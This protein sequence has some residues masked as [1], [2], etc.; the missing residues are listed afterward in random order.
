MKIKS[1][2]LVTLF[3]VLLSANAAEKKKLKA[4]QP[5]DNSTQQMVFT[6][7]QVIDLKRSSSINLAIK[8]NAL[9][10]KNKK[11]SNIKI[12]TYEVSKGNRSLIGVNN[13]SVRKNTRIFLTSI[14]LGY[15][16]SAEKLVEFEIYDSK[17]KL[18]NTYIATVTA[19]N[20]A[21]QELQANQIDA[22]LES[23]I[24]KLNFEVADSQ[25]SVVKQTDGSYKILLSNRQINPKSEDSVPRG[26]FL[27]IRTTSL[28]TTPVEGLIEYD[29]DKLYFTRANGR[30]E[31]GATGPVGP[32]GP[33]GPEGPQG[34][35]GNNGS[36]GSPG[37][38]GPQGPAGVDGGTGT[39][40]SRTANYTIIPTDYT[41][42][43]NSTGGTFTVTLPAA[44]TNS[45]KVFYIRKT[46]A[47]AN[48]VIL[49]GNA[50]E[51]IDGALTYNITV[52]NE[53][54][55][56]QSDGTNWLMI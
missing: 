36:P 18:I 40:L 6:E 26:R 46:D 43:C 41:I 33:A 28:R 10:S 23:I 24:S 7:S 50:S 44:A 35:R 15:F 4:L 14:D 47:S 48:R 27:R 19:T 2:I 25:T 42:S 30:S 9:V 52:Q 1:I 49:D 29:G 16:A 5:I 31:L 3:S 21:S 13:L 20:L 56:V 38:Q 8:T 12:K 32:Q 22:S 54:I 37:P 34:P 53:T 45:G 17:D 55:T 51:T 11:N 39:L